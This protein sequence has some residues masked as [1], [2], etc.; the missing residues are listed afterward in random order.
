[1]NLLH[2][3]GSTQVCSTP[4]KKEWRAILLGTTGVQ[5]LYSVRSWRF[6]KMPIY[7][8]AYGQ[9]TQY[10]DQRFDDAYAGLQA[11]PELGLAGGRLRTSV[12]GVERWYG[13][14]PLVASF[15]GELEYEKLVGDA[16]AGGATLLLRH[17]DYHRR[18]DADV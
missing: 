13:R 16:W 6:G 9:W 17:N 2:T 3:L 11:G 5:K 14:R 12:T 1:M 10:R 8:G 18:S 4:S 15:G 7:V